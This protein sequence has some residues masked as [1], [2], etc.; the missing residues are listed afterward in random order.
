M[1]TCL[2]GWRWVCF[3]P[4]CVWGRRR[5]RPARSSLMTS[6]GAAPQDLR[7]LCHRQWTVYQFLQRQPHAS[8]TQHSRPKASIVSARPSHT[9]THRKT[10][11]LV[12]HVQTM[13]RGGVHKIIMKLGTGGLNYTP[14]KMF[15]VKFRNYF[16]DVI[17]Q[18]QTKNVRL[19]CI[20]IF[21]TNQKK[22]KTA[23]YHGCRVYCAFP[24]IKHTF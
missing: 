7:R 10:P 8:N 1:P 5:L 2:P 17:T 19:Y 9:N 3:Q 12:S 6:V 24:A 23:A 13:Q 22:Q 16:N 4:S 11:T 14:W 21:K 20:Q 15:A 18:L